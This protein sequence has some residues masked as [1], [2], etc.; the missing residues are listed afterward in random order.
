MLCAPVWGEDA[1]VMGVSL[2]SGLSCC[3]VWSPAL[4]TQLSQ[5]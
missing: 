3:D 4:W 2:D 1:H 5:A